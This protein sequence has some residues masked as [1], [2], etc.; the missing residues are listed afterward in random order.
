MKKQLSRLISR[1]WVQ[2]GLQ[3]K[4]IF[5]RVVV[6]AMFWYLYLTNDLNDGSIMQIRSRGAVGPLTG[7]TPAGWCTP[8]ACGAAGGRR[9]SGGPPATSGS[10]CWASGS[11]SSRWRGTR[12][13][14]GAPPAGPPRRGP[15]APTAGWSEEEEKL[16][17]RKPEPGLSTL[18]PLVFHRIVAF[19]YCS[20]HWY[21]SF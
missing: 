2:Q 8:W 6:V 18:Y 16:F 7:R 9:R 20:V 3:L 17:P 21:Y 13:R 12:W 14:R 4:I 11:A 1:R 15:S 19:Y 10:S 5:K